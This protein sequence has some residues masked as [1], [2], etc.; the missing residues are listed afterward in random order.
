MAQ[1]RPA[2]QTFLLISTLLPVAGHAATHTVCAV[3]CDYMSIQPAVLASSPS[4]TI[5]VQDSRLYSEAITI[6]TPLFVTTSS[7]ASLGNFAPDVVTVFGGGDAE[8]SGFLVDGYGFDRCFNVTDGGILG[9][10]DM[11]VQNCSFSQSG[12]AVSL[13]TSSAGTFVNVDFID[14]VSLVSGGSISGDGATIDITD[15]SFTQTGAIPLA[16]VG[17]AVHAIDSDVT[18]T[19]SQ[20]VGMRSGDDGGALAAINGTLTLRAVVFD[21]NIAQG[22]GKGGAVFAESLDFFTIE[23]STFT[24]NEAVQ[25]GAMYFGA[26]D[27]EIYRN[28]WCENSATIGGAMYIAGAGG[29]TYQSVKNNRFVRNSATDFGG[30]MGAFFV[31]IDIVNNTFVGNEAGSGGGIQFAGGEILV[32][33][34]VIA[35]TTGVGLVADNSYFAATANRSYNLWYNNSIS[36]LGGGISDA[37]DLNTPGIIVDVVPLF[38]AYS[39]NSDCDDRL[40]PIP[41]S[42]LIDAGDPLLF[43]LDLSRS[44]IGAYGGADAPAEH[45]AD[46]DADGFSTAQ[47]DCDDLD[48]TL[49]PGAVEIPA[50]GV[51]TDCDR[52][53]DCYVDADNDGFG[54]ASGI[55]VP[56]TFLDCDAAGLATDTDD[57]DDSD[58]TIHPGAQEGTADLVDQDCD[59]LERCYQDQDDDDAG[60]NV[61]V[62]SAA[63]DCDG[64]NVHFTSDDC[65]D[66]NPAIYPGAIEVVADGVDQD[67]DGGEDCFLDADGDGVGTPAIQPSADLDCADGLEATTF[68]DCDDGNPA[69]YPL[70]VEIPA[71]DI[72]QDC[73]GTEKCYSDTDGDGYGAGL[74]TSL[75]DLTCFGV[76]EAYLDGDCDDSDAS[77][78]PGQ[79]ESVG[80]GVDQDCDGWELCYIDADFDGFGDNAGGTTASDLT[81]MAAGVAPVDGD[82]DDG[83][84]AVFPSA[85]EVVGDLVDQDCD[86]FEDCFVDGDQDTFG[87]TAT[88][89][90]ADLQCLLAR[91]E[92]TLDTDC[93][94]GDSSIHPS[95]IEVV[96]DGIDQDCNGFEV[97]Y[98]DNDGD[99]SPGDLLL[100]DSPNLGCDG[101]GEGTSAPDCDDADAQ[102]FPGALEVAGD[103]VD[104]DCDGFEAC[105]GDSDGDGYGIDPELISVNLGCDGLAESSV[106]TDCDDAD[107]T[108]YPNAPEIIGDGIDQDCDGS[109]LVGCYQDLDLDG[110]GDDVVIYSGNPQC[111]NPGEALVSGDCDETDP[112]IYP[113]APDVCDGV[114]SD[115]DGDG[116]PDSDEDGDGLTWLVEVLA[117]INPCDADTDRDLLLDGDEIDLLT[118]PTLVDSDADGIDDGTEVGGNPLAPLDTDGDG[119]IDALDPDDDGDGVPTLEEPGDTDADGTPDR[120]DGDDDGDGIDTLDEDTDGDGD[121]TDDDADGDALPNYLDADSDDDGIDD[122]DEVVA[123]TDPYDPDSD[124]DGLDDGVEDLLGTDPLAVDTDGDG[125]WDGDEV[126][127]GTNPLLTDTDGDGDSDGSDCAPL[128]PSRY[129]G[130]AELCNAIDDDCDGIDDDNDPDTIGSMAWYLD[131][132]GDAYGLSGTQI[133]ACVPPP[134]RID[135]D[136]DC[137]DTDPSIHPGAAE[138][139]AD[140]TDSDCDL[141]EECYEDIDGD[142]FAGSSTHVSADFIC[143]IPPDYAVNADCDDAD[144]TVFPGAVELLATGIDEDCDG[145]ELCFVD[146]DSD[147][148]GGDAAVQ[149]ASP[150]ID[151]SAPSVSLTADDCADTDP[152]INPGANEVPADGIDADCDGRE[153]CYADADNDGFGNA[154]SVIP[155]FDLLCAV[156]GVSA[157]PS[158]CD[159]ADPNVNPL[160]AEGPGDEI[161]ADCDGTEYCFVDG[162]LDGSGTDTGETVFSDD[163]DCQDPGESNNRGDCDDSDAGIGP[164]SPELPADGLDSDC[165]LFELCYLDEDGDGFGGETLIPSEDFGC[166]GD[167]MTSSEMDCDDTNPLVFPGA[168]EVAGDG[169]DGDCDGL[170]LCFVDQDLDG[171]GGSTTTAGSDLVCTSAGISLL[172]TDCDDADAEVFPGA[173]ELA[174]DGVDQDCDGTEFCFRDDDEDGFGADDGAVLA[175]F[176]V[177]CTDAGESDT[178]DDCNDEDPSVYPG[179]PE[180]QSKVDRNCDGHTD[181]VGKLMLDGCGCST[182]GPSSLPTLA[183]LAV[184]LVVRRRRV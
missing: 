114:D 58:G 157:D 182:G 13:K 29:V 155:V 178:P 31:W 163:T 65:N 73:D 183:W 28:Q 25:G 1:L 164:D 174:A 179:A 77:I 11:T 88:V 136:T 138:I 116:G 156:P 117:G 51:D 64:P 96:A 113:G 85:P 21:A 20:F 41:A 19:D 104:E 146:G 128:D 69:I 129:A 111:D 52:L 140:G 8:F 103:G 124:G 62:I 72:D 45:Y 83:S 161:D 154:L 158:D 170:E 26:A 153:D 80:D 167:G 99:G 6:T 68:D 97:C 119:T 36:H 54:D 107:P 23:D 37:V 149:I 106:N 91:Q 5:D 24:H 162:D 98:I 89:T 27:L 71:D 70:A 184:V 57:C 4:D 133:D 43:D 38:T 109:D 44:D 132:D 173:E 50:D 74:T 130:A 61:I 100:L 118:D 137:D 166:E 39:D 160:A 176:D 152:A 82:C 63:I 10:R 95:A 180:D 120:L 17:G 66:G 159:D 18:V 175:S 102:V 171:F 35:N 47:G 84:D 148:F 150:S 123:G 141:L 46:V 127:I 60:S 34:N 168:Q 40:W 90:S 110:Y 3:G 112:A 30:A 15:C 125:L 115:C 16:F 7:G 134:G 33:N 142:G 79:L 55:T 122:G 53:E 75:G 105:F 86:G 76:I 135:N 32:S 151:C 81:C 87:S 139:P 22:T 126:L 101:P 67:C 78:F 181:T 144:A 169:V 121:P 48:P 9:L 56:S 143:A 42:P 93:D 49:H 177:D 131:D 108:R 94:D 14:N 147:G 92:S 145:L 12:A 172:D 2:L 165:D 59:G